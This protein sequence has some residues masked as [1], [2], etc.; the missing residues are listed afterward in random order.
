MRVSWNWR[1]SLEPKRKGW[2]VTDLREAKWDSLG[3]IASCILYTLYTFIYYISP[4]RAGFWRLAAYFISQF[5]F[6][7]VCAACSM[8]NDHTDSRERSAMRWRFSFE[9]NPW[10]VYQLAIRRN[11]ENASKSHRG[12]HPLVAPSSNEI[13]CD[14]SISFF[15]WKITIIKWYLLKN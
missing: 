13:R 3:D 11:E 1:G 2:L 15:Q 4:R 10:C 5:R 14:I 6:P 7:F 12:W 8:S 9:R